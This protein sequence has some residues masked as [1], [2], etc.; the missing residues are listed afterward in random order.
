V[1]IRIAVLIDLDM[2]L[3]ISCSEEKDY[4]WII[5]EE[6]IEEKECLSDHNDLQSS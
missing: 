2:K 1:K 6:K 5:P 3:K 4:Q